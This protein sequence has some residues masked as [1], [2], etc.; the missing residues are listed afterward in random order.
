MD[1]A[2]GLYSVL[3]MPDGHLGALKLQKNFN[4]HCSSQMFFRLVEM[5]F[6]LVHASYSLPEWQAVRMTFFAS[7]FWVVPSCKLDCSSHLFSGWAPCAVRQFLHHL[8][9]I[10]GF[11]GVFTSEHPFRQL[12]FISFR[13]LQDPQETQDRLACRGAVQRHH[14]WGQVLR[15]L[16][17]IAYLVKRVLKD[18]KGT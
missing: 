12:P 4:Q 9:K 18:P 8:N 16:Q 1:F 5:T 6:G 7:W 3:S 10:L 11:R 2:I 15:P 14:D 13:D 17:Y